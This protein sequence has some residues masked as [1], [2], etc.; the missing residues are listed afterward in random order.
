MIAG[1]SDGAVDPG[2]KSFRDFPAWFR[3]HRDELLAGKTRV[4]MFCT[5]GIR[6]EKAGPLLA[7]EGYQVFQLEDG[8]LGYFE[9]CGGAH[10]DG[11][12]FVFDERGG[13]DESLAPA[14]PPHPGS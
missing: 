11:T 7:R 10:Y 3:D 9:A 4:A 2:T 14:A 13:V 5:G 1:V 8:I 6:C 12:C